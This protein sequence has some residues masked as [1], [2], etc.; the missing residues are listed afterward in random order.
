MAVL[1]ADRCGRGGHRRCKRVISTASTCDPV[2]RARA[3]NAAGS[4]AWQRQDVRAPGRFHEEALGTQRQCGDQAG[5]AW[6][7]ACLAPYR[8]FAGP[9]DEAVRYANDSLAFSRE[10]STIS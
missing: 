9:W 6:S 8:L 3:P 1:A 7:L 5:G 4:M 2:L 10:S